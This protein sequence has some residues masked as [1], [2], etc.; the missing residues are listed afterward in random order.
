MITVKAHALLM[1]FEYYIDACGIAG[2]VLMTDDSMVVGG[3]VGTI[4]ARV[5]ETMVKLAHDAG[6]IPDTLTDGPT[7]RVIALTWGNMEWPKRWPIVVRGIA[8]SST[9]A[10]LSGIMDAHDID[11]AL[12]AVDD[13]YK[14]L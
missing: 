4:P 13:A 10:Q 2:V 1:N 12:A 6:V 3:T 9:R 5:G 14:P 7:G 8:L 11:Q